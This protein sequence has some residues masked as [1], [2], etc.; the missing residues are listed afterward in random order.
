MSQQRPRTPAAP[1]S[2][3]ASVVTRDTDLYLRKTPPLPPRPPQRV[4]T[5]AS[6]SFEMRTHTS[7]TEAQVWANVG[8]ERAGVG[9]GNAQLSRSQA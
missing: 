7:I 1:G 4:Q 6:T 2:V 3:L 5:P 8:A 9:A